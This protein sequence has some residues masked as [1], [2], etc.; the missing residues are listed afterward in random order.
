MDDF[1]QAHLEGLYFGLQQSDLERVEKERAAERKAE[2]ALRTARGEKGSGMSDFLGQVV[3]EA[4]SF[5]KEL[6]AMQAAEKRKREVAA[7]KLV[8]RVPPPTI[9]KE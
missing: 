2:A 4:D 6:V 8:G 7:Q 9:T 1:T 5:D 3:Q